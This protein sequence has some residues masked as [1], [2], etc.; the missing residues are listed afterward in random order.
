MSAIT[1]KA[2]D[3]I[4]ELKKAQEKFSSGVKDTIRRH[5]TIIQGDITEEEVEEVINSPEKGEEMLKAKLLNSPSVQLESAVS[6]I[7]DKY[8]DIV[9]LERVH[10]GIKVEHE[11]MP[12]N[13]E[14][15]GAAGADTGIEVEQ[16][17]SSNRSDWG[18][19]A[20]G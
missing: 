3:A 11:R 1:K 9:Q 13:D 6:D 19:H 2:R 17:R 12:G 5:A 16:H 4:S 18:L 15:V 7:M 8:R 14:R 10:R 20:E